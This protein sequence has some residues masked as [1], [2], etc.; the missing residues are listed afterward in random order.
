MGTCIADIV[1]AI[2]IKV[3]NNVQDEPFPRFKFA[4]QPTMETFVVDRST[5]ETMA[6]HGQRTQRKIQQELQA[7]EMKL[8]AA[9]DERKRAWK[10][11]MKVK[12][13]LESIAS[14]NN[15][16]P[17]YKPPPR[18]TTNRN[19][20]ELVPKGDSNATSDARYAKVVVSRKK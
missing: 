15:T 11:L 12:A 14:Q 8:N 10:K 16:M 9:E 18:G 2:D 17:E 1:D 7:V 19:L 20:E 13:E 5:G 6:Q 3:H 4:P